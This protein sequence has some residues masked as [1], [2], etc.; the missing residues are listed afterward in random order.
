MSQMYWNPAGDR[1]EEWQP[2]G[3]WNASFSEQDKI[4][5]TNLFFFLKNK[6]GCNTP[7]AEIMAHM[8][9]FKQKYKLKYSEEQERQI[10]EVLLP[11]CF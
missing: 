3:G 8:V 6:K 1:M 4:Q 2:I 5:L 9:V 11:V 10:R 7:K